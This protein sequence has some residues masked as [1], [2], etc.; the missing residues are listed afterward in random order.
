LDNL[1]RSTKFVQRES[2]VTAENFL[3]LLLKDASCPVG[4]SLLD[5]SNEFLSVHHVSISAQGIEDRFNDYAVKFMRGLVN[6]FFSQQFS[7]PFD[8]PFL[9]RYRSFRIWDSTK[10]ELPAFLADDFPGF[11]GGA[12]AAGISIQCRYDLKNRVC[13]SLDVYPATYS[14]AKYTED[15]VV[16]ENCLDIFD[17]GYVSASFLQRLEDGGGHYVCRLH[18]QSGVYDR[19]GNELDF[20]KTYSWMRQHGISV[21]EKDV[22]VSEKF[23]TSRLVISLVDD[24]TYQKRLAKVQ[25]DGRKKGRQVSDRYK[26][27]MHMNLI[28]TNTDPKEIPDSKVYLL[29][30]FRWQI[31]LMFKSWK[32]SGWNLENIKKVKYERYMCI[33]YA[34]LLMIILSN[35]IHG[36]MARKR[37]LKDKKI[38]SGNKCAKTLCQQIDLLRKLINASAIR[39]Y[40]ILEKIDQIFARGHILCQ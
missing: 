21:Y 5:Y 25:K 40:E 1:A 28:L 13:S 36:V 26:A 2:R 18:S 20:Q 16:E 4:M 27:R 30:K 7:Q 23:I 17:L 33:L 32:S 9:E 19:D 14:D 8:V 31:E 34:K 11:G 39:I 37:Y 38:L 12:S 6:H 22:W 35:Q 10:L 29:Y 3:D 24:Q 15:F